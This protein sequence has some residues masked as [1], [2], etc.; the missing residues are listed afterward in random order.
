MLVI[1]A[2]WRPPRRNNETGSLFFWAESS[3]TE[4]PYY[5][6]GRL[7]KRQPPKPHMFSLSGEEF[8]DRIGHGTPLAKASIEVAK[9]RIPSTRTG[10]VPSPELAHHW[11]LD[12]TT[13]LF[14]APWLIEGLELSSEIAFVVLVSLP[15][16]GPKHSYVLGSDAL[17]WR[18]AANLV[19]EIL[20][21][22]K[23]VPVLNATSGQGSDR[24]QAVWEALWMAKMMAHVVARLAAAM[25]PVCMMELLHPNGRYNTATSTHPTANAGN[26]SSTR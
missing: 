3:D 21:A 10:P 7:P 2:H 19:M 22:Q 20:A 1:H 26:A 13:D 18:K 4:E 23:V 17:Y 24:F 12:T 25:P 15:L 8:R 9:L 5:F 14:L 11:N 16:Q 6:K